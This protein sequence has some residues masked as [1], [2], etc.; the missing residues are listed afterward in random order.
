M[1]GHRARQLVAVALLAV[2]GGAA[3]WAFRHEN[4]PPADL[5]FCNGTE[6]KTIDPAQVT[7]QPEGRVVDAVFEGLCR[8]DPSDLRPIPGV[9]ERWE[10]SDDLRVYTFHLRRDARWSDGSSVT[11]DD[12]VYSWRR[13][14]SPE[15]A[16]EYAYQLWYVKN[17]KR[18]ST[19]KVEIG[20]RV[21]VELPRPADVPNT[22]R[23]E[24]LVGTLRAVDKLDEQTVYDVE[25]DGR[26]RKFTKEAA[27]AQGDV[28]RCAW[29]L[30]SFEYVGVRVADPYTLVVTLENPTPFFLDIAAFYPLSPV[31]RKCLETHGSPW[32]TRP[33]NVVGNGPF[34]IESRRIRD[35]VRL[36]KNEHYWNRDKVRLN[37]VDVLAVEGT[38]TML[39]LYLTG[40]VDWITTVPAP[41]APRLIATRP[42]E[43]NP[44]PILGTYFYRFNVTKPPLDRADVRRA[45][46][47][48]LDR[49]EIVKTV[50]RMGEIPA[51]SLVPPGLAGYTSAPYVGGENVA[52][53]KRL[54]AAAGFPD[55][56]G[57]PK[58]EILY[59]T[60]EPHKAIAEL[61]Q[62]RWKRTL[63]ID[64]GLRNQEWGVFLDTVRQK[65]YDVARA[66][67]IG[68]Y[69]DPNTFLDM[70]MSDN[71]NNQT[72]WKN[73]DYDRLVTQAAAEPDVAKRMQTLHN[74]EAILMQE[75]P[76]APIY[77][78]VSK[79]MVRPYI[80]GFHENLRDEHP[81]WALAIDPAAKQ[82][83]MQAEG[84]P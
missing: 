20:E 32:W 74:A 19:A 1:D 82:A 17:A 13:F 30:P 7:G 47:L 62:D 4:R 59:N 83:V 46:T 65:N 29:V 25:I 58:V 40:Q 48:V 31:N 70:F 71:E 41:L 80:E 79:D 14:L 23:G 21:E 43:F 52:E 34:R 64:V 66:G 56:R 84:R 8:R 35:R 53:A 69:A 5:T 16:G 76:I 3:L 72:G 9:A 77:F 42:K 44:S 26:R 24:V 61:I 57:F 28:A 39:N 73:A 81:L 36:V 10:I 49:N 45:L 2:L 18:Y 54:L 63:G 50:T 33:E 27:A 51:F 12:F 6:I 60:Q 67:W 55:G 37:T 15:T 78:Y 11:A 68:D 75:L 38:T 22:V